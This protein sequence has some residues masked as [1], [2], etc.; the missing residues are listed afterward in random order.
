MRVRFVGT[1]DPTF[2]RH[3]LIAAGL[4]ARGITVA[5]TV[6]PAWGSTGDRVG[7]AKKGLRNPGL[8]LRLAAAYLR[9]TRLLRTSPPGEIWY[10]GYPG[11]L[12]TIVLRA[13]QPQ[14]PIVLDGFISLSETLAD[15]ALGS[16]ASRKLAALLDRL[17][18]RL[19]DRVVVDTAAHRRRYS[20]DLGLP[21]H[22][23][24]LVPVG[25]NDPGP[26]PPAPT[27]GPL[28]VLY[29]GGFIPLHGVNIIVE[30]ARRLPT[31][32]GI[33]IT[34]VGDGQD[35]DAVESAL[36]QNP[37]SNLRL[38]RSWMTETELVTQ[39]IA[40]AHVCL[41]IFAAAP[42]AMDVVPA[43]AFLSLACERTLVTAESPAVAEELR[44]RAT[45]APPLLTCA[46]GDPEALVSL[47]FQL[48]R[49]R[50][51]VRRTAAAGRAL[52][53]RRFRPELIVEQLV[54]ALETISHQG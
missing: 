51:L 25:A 40:H 43:K 52:Y 24:V 17:A 19:A 44:A 20:H 38:V 11:Q 45:S 36:E 41:G 50:D 16:P 31:D 23:A 14:R 12:D 39:H 4:R 26:I 21:A 10:V 29:F 1:H 7:A 3:V 32:G 35:A 33:T 13:L 30:A 49:D 5:S 48:Q 9:I 22:H 15:R 2:G 8:A 27:E 28:R 34:L 47:L 42:K 54:P 46:P 18:F 37:A 53:E 6:D